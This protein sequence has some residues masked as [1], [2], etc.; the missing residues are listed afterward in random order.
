MENQLVTPALFQAMRDAGPLPVAA[1]AT[2]AEYLD[3]RRA[4]LNRRL[5]E[6]VA[7][8]A[9][10]TLEYIQIKEGEMKDTPLKAVTPEAA[11]TAADRLYGMVPSVRV[12]DIL[13]EVD[14]WTGFSRAF[15]HLHTGL[16]AADPRACA[17]RG[18]GMA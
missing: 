2:A 1:P 16:P 11:E 18:G 3:R 9:T 6:V 14:G 13:A 15:T 17:H 8:V 5:A 10:D 7:K 12:T 4:L